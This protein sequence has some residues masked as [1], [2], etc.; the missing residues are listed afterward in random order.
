MASSF[1]FPS[2][3]KARA[4]V[5]AALLALPAAGCLRKGPEV[6][7]SIAPGSPD[8]AR[9]QVQT[10]GARFE[11]NPAD[12][13]AGMAYARALRANDQHA[14]AVAVLQQA[15]IRNPKHL[16]LLA[17]YGKALAD[18]GRLKEAAEVLSRAHTP[19]RPDW[20]ILSAQGA[21]ADQLGDHA[22]AQ[23]YYEAALKIAPGEPTVLSN[24]GL[25]LALAKRLPEAET[26]LRRAAAVSSADARVRQNLSLVLGLQGKFAEAEEV[27]RRDLAPAEAAA[28]VSAMKSLVAQPNSWQAIKSAEGKKPAK[29]KVRAAAAKPAE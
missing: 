19:E 24:L 26:T 17:A 13:D 23:R 10:W 12:A 6:T 18:A 5:V 22:T 3:L 29:A 9:Q 27:M 28:N 15:A 20:R 16:P 21:V 2:R 11:A 1:L 7:G 4:L 25:S 8:A 14:Q